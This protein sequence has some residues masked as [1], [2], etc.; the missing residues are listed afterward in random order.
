[1][2]AKDENDENFD[3]TGRVKWSVED[4][5]GLTID[6]TTGDIEF[7]QPGNYQIYAIVNDTESNLVP[8]QVRARSGQLETLTVNG[9]I[10]DLIY[11]DDTA[12]TF[13]LSTL[14]VEA[15]DQY[16]EDMT[17]DESLFE[18]R[19]A[20]DKAMPK[21]AAARSPALSSARIPLPCITR[22]DRT[23]TASRFTKRRSR[24]PYR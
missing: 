19:L 11:N 1:M 22:L 3:V 17:L 13:D 6:E 15:K 14:I 20:T 24:C 7:T 9:T 21:S 10:P 5:D 12:N 16:G 8:L 2:T 4:N 23:K 18:W